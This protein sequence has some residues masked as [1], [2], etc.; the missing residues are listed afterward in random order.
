MEGFVLYFLR[1][2]ATK[3]NLGMILRNRMDVNGFFCK[4]S[5]CEEG[6]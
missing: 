1:L 6:V 4:F 3:M 5:E 2:D